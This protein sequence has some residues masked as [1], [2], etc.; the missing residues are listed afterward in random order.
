M[1]PLLLPGLLDAARYNAAHGRPGVACSSPRT[2]T[3]RPARSSGRP[4]LAARGAARREPHHLSRADDRGG[5]GRLAQRGARRPTSTPPR[6][7]LEALLGGGRR[8]VARRAASAAVPASGP[9]RGGADRRR[10]RSAG[11][12]SCTRSSR[13]SGTS[14]A[15]PPRS[16]STST[17]SLELSAGG[18]EVYGDVTSFPAVLQD[19]AVVVAEDVPAS[20][21]EAAVRAGGGDLLGALARVRRLPGRA[22]GRGQQVARAAARVPRA[23]PHAHRR[24]GRGAPRRRSSASSSPIGGRLR[25]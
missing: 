11:S 14:T 23:R 6:A 8:R 2:S 25:A 20:R 5:A 18:L 21:V 22:G 16:S 15:R 19:I 7:L 12:A 4:G 10:P 3:A 9:L 13:A 24:G 17:R 1:R